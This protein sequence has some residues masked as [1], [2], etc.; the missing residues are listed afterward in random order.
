[1]FYG[2]NPVPSGG[3]FGFRA[4][5]ATQSLIARY[6]ASRGQP[7]LGT[8]GP[9][10]PAVP[11]MGRTALVAPQVNTWAGAGIPRINPA[12]I[13]AAAAAAQ[14]ALEASYGPSLAGTS[15]FDPYSPLDP[16]NAA[17]LKANPFFR[18]N[19]MAGGGSPGGVG[20]PSG[21]GSPGPGDAGEGV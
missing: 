16:R 19:F 1:M 2:F 10:V 4:N 18:T 15:S 11:L 7:A 3:Y 12:S 8:G 21:E 9:A 5:P 6:L 13:A 20:A 17:F 14:A